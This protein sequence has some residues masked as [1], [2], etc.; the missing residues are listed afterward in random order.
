MAD[1]PRILTFLPTLIPPSP[2]SVCVTAAC[3]SAL[4][5]FKN[6]PSDGGSTRTDPIYLTFSLERL[7]ARRRCLVRSC[8]SPASV[9]PR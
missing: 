8:S 2:H 6:T 1:D 9:A 5:C 7:S 3:V 4:D